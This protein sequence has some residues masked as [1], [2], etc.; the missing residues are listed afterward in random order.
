MHYKFTCLNGQ[1]L[2]SSPLFPRS[3]AEQQFSRLSE[4]LLSW[5]IG[6]FFTQFTHKKKDIQYRTFTFIYFTFFVRLTYESFEHKK[7][8]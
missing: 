7:G 2:E 8:A 5:D 4:G 1:S 6:C 3:Q